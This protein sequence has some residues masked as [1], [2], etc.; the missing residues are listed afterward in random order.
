MLDLA[1]PALKLLWFE[2]VL[3]HSTT[4]PL[5][6]LSSQSYCSVLSR[7]AA[8]LFKQ[9]YCNVLWSLSWC[10]KR[11]LGGNQDIKHKKRGWLNVSERSWRTWWALGW[12]GIALSKGGQWLFKQPDVW[13]SFRWRDF[14]LVERMPFWLSVGKVNTFVELLFPK[15]LSQ[16]ICRHQLLLICLLPLLIDKCFSTS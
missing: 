8:C 13:T 16:R 14:I 4:I 12:R 3:R 2:G 5:W 6:K 1:S 11:C 10:R 7:G 15:A 9:E